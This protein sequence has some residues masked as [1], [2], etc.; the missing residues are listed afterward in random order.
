MARLSFLPEAVPFWCAT[1]FSA[2]LTA[3][4]FRWIVLPFF[5]QQQHRNG[6]A[7]FAE[8]LFEKFEVGAALVFGGLPSYCKKNASTPMPLNEAW[9]MQNGK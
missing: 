3:L 2:V 9:I 6:P 1:W 4:R 5:I 8:R 7:Q